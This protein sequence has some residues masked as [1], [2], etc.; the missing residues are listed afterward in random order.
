MIEPLTKAETSAGRILFRGQDGYKSSLPLED[1]LASDVLL[2]DQLNGAP[3]TIEH[4]APLRLVAPAHYGYK[5]VKHVYRIDLLPE[6]GSDRRSWMRFLD[7]PRGRVALEERGRGFPGWFLRFV[8]RPLIGPTRR[9]F[10]K[11]MAEH[12]TSAREIDRDSPEH[13]RI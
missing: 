13:D 12:M 5:S 1:L 4:G 6:E 9:R 7:H 8:F 11:A 10:Q 2:A 3:L